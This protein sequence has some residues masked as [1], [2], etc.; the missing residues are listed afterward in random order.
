MLRLSGKVG[1]TLAKSENMAKE[2][3][4]NYIRAHRMRRGLSQREL[5][6]LVGYGDGHAVGKHERSNAVP[7]LLIALAYEVV[8]EIPV[9]QLFV[10]FRSAVAESVE[11]NV[12]EL[13]AD[14]ENQSGKRRSVPEKMQW[15]SKQYVG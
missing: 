4:G 13:K 12:R 5:A 6:I 10:G 1:K 8:F 3:V 9:A 11:R 14:L 15:L 7:P 2:V